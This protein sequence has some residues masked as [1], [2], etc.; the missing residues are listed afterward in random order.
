[1]IDYERE[2]NESQ[3]AAVQYCDGPSLVIA[4]AGSGKTRVLTFKIAWLLEHGYQPWSIMALTFTNKAAQEMKERIGRQVGDELASQLWMGTFHSLFAKFLRR[5][6]DVVGFT[7]N[8]TI[9]DQSDSRSLVKAIIK[10]MGLDDK[11]YKPNAVHARISD[12]KNRLLTPQLYAAS[13]EDY[14]E[15]QWRRIPQTRDIYA[16]YQERLRL[17]DAMDFDDLLM[18]TYY[19]FRDHPDV[20]DRYRRRFRY[21]LVDEYQDTNLAQHQIVWQLTEEHQHVCVVG[22]DSQSIYSFRGANIDNIL[23]FQRRYTDAQLFKL[24][25]N[26]R[27]T[28][29]IVKAANSVIEH[30]VRRIPKEVYSNKEEGTP[31]TVFEAVSDKEEAGYVTRQILALTKRHRLSL[32]DIAILY[33][34]NGQSRLFEETLRKSNVLYRIYGGLSFYQRKEIKDVMAYF[35]LIGNPHDEEA[36]KRVVNY[37]ARGIGDTTVSRLMQAAT[38]DGVSPWHLLQEPAQHDTDLKGAPLARLQQFCAMID[39]FRQL[40]ATA[41]AYEVAKAVLEQSG[42]RH[43]I[44]SDTSDEGRSRQENVQELMDGIADFVRSARE[45]GREAVALTDYLADVS[46]LTDQDNPHGDDAPH[47]TLMTVHSAKGL[48]F[49][50]VFVVGMEEDL[51]PNEMCGDEPSSVEEERRLFYVA[52]TRAEERCFLTYA[53]SRFRFGNMEYGTRSRFIAEIDDQYL[54]SGNTTA[55]RPAPDYPSRSYGSGSRYGNYDS[56]SRYGSS[57]SDRRYGS[58]YGRNPSGSTYGKPAP[59]RSV[60]PSRPTPSASQPSPSPAGSR[61]LVSLRTGTAMP[62]STGEGGGAPSLH[63]G[64]HVEHER[65]GRGEVLSVSGEAENRRAVVRFDN[66]GE[67]TLLLKFARFQVLD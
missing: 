40:A 43:D 33:R 44:F 36:F 1:M 38:R 55:A 8:F 23:G 53:K 17:S 27:S 42:I 48:E 22:D 59:S 29:T 35:R 60:N 56:G 3:L 13:R 46:L 26:Y 21:L 16:R 11:V 7:Q 63:A 10:E 52:L 30:N 54:V 25:Q 49:N 65:F 57:D 14:D 61:R 58:S 50:T 24:E 12:A 2:L 34:T 37:P 5:E 39:H 28:Q 19:L 64:Q 18:T 62:A 41:D 51:F 66:A 45:E 31:L 4:G 15:D 6:H 67:K 9:Y 32:S 47:V 20:L